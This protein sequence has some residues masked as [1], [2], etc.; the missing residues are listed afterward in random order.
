[1]SDS[2]P[3]QKIALRGQIWVV[4]IF[5]GVATVIGGWLGA[6]VWLLSR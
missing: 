6:I 2:A 4:V 5:L 3:T 1:M